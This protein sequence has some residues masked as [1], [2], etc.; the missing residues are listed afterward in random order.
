MLREEKFTYGVELFVSSKKRLGGMSGLTPSYAL[1]GA[2]TAFTLKNC[3]A[4]GQGLFV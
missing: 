1:H 3:Q 4:R 2:A